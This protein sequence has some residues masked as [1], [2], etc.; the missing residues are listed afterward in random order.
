MSHET[1]RS[2]TNT[3]SWLGIAITLLPLVPDALSGTAG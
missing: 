2:K 1:L 3:A